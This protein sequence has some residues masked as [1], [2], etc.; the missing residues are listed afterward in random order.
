LWKTLDTGACVALDFVDGGYPSTYLCSL[1][2]LLALHH[3]L[4][5]HA[6]S[7]GADWVVV[8]IADGLLQRETS[9]LLQSAAFRETVD[10]WVFATND[11]LGAVGGLSVLRTWGIT[12]AA[13]SGILTASPLAMRE[14][15]AATGVPC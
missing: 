14:A 3:R 12:P 13:I 5:S 10:A 1:T 8:E 15:Q 7:R 2:E 4:V 9:Q 6:A 11:A